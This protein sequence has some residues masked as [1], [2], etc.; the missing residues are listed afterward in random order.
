MRKLKQIFICFAVFVSITGK[1][2]TQENQSVTAEKAPDPRALLYFIDLSAKAVDDVVRDVL[3]NRL[4]QEMRDLEFPTTDKPLFVH[5][6]VPTAIVD[7]ETGEVNSGAIRPK[8]F[9]AD[10]PYPDVTIIIAVF[11]QLEGSSLLIQ[12]SLYDPTTGT[13][14]GGLFVRAR[15]GLTLFNSVNDA[16]TELRPVLQDYMQNPYE[17]IQPQ[18]RVE[19][20]HATSNQEQIQ[21]F[22]AG[23]EVGVTAQ[24]ELLVPYSPFRIGTNV[25]MELRKPGYH[26]Q[27]SVVPMDKAQVDLQ[28]PELWKQN[29]MALQAYWT[30]GMSRGAGLAFDIYIE[31]DQSYF[32]VYTHLH[33]N[34]YHALEHV[35]PSFNYDFGLLYG[36]YIIFPPESFIR[37][38]IGFGVGVYR[39]TFDNPN[40][41]DF[42]DY[43]LN[44]GAPTV[45]LNLKPIQFFA[46]VDLK[47]ALGIGTNLLGR[48]WIQ[49]VPNLPNI[50]MGVQLKW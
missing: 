7:P 13:G 4:T 43:Y 33:D 6:P 40:L 12:F 39:T 1:V 8:D 29:R 34:A 17:Y 28:L 24:G 23:K 16:V 36:S 44:L 30:L 14:V 47:Y 18:G 15:A 49:T 48:V 20:I 45:E 31:P 10:L 22:F 35:S 32:Q 3:V 11:Y 9:F 19:Q 21:V 37:L 41:G 42:T 27:I 46:R 38:S 2:W 5:R 25:R 50:S 26:S